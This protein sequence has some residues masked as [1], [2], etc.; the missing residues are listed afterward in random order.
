MQG[1]LRRRR[2]KSPPRRKRERVKKH[3]PASV[4]GSEPSG[5]IDNNTEY[6]VRTYSYM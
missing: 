6:Y 3:R 4:I 1:K 5:L 2:V